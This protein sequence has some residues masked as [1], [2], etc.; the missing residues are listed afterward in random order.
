MDP[1]EVKNTREKEMKYL[2]NMEVYEYST[3]AE[4]RA[5]TGRKPVGLKWIDPT[6]G[7]A[8]VS[9]R[10]W[11]VRNC[12]TKGSNRSSRQRFRWKLCDSY[13]VLRVRKTFFR[14]EAHFNAD[15]VRDVYIRL[16][17]VD[18]KE[19]QPGVCGKLRKT[20][21]GSLDAAQRWRELYAQVFG[22]GRIFPRRGFSVPLLP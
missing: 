10:V 8:K 14:V 18:P 12:A 13:S 22:G 2:W 21:Y 15:A 9:V 7:N 17:D 5:R 19:K 6:K 20:M 1:H 3:D 16:P 11:C 4:A